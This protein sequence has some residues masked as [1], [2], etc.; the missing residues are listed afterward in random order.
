MKTMK[1]NFTGYRFN[2]ISIKMPKVLRDLFGHSS[3]AK[4]KLYKTRFYT[5]YGF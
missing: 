2:R 1:N 5:F 4:F 3:S